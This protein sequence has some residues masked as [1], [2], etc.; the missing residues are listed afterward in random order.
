M[1][2]R[3]PLPPA[4]PRC[5]PFRGLWR[6]T[7]GGL[8]R[9]SCERGRMLGAGKVKRVMPGRVQNRAEEILPGCLETDTSRPPVRE[10]R[11]GK[12]AACGD[13]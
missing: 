5:A 2:P 4:C 10:V 7:A 8:A 3:I 1:K 11:D 12:L 13:Q 6:M 9:C